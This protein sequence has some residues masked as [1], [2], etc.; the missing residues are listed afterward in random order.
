MSSKGLWSRTDA[1]VIQI[2]AH[3]IAAAT[4]YSMRERLVIRP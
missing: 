1:V 2:E 3:K 4:R